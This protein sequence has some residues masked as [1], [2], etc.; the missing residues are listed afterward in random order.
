MLFISIKPHTECSFPNPH[1]ILYTVLYTHLLLSYR[2][3]SQQMLENLYLKEA[4]E[5]LE[6]SQRHRQM[7]LEN[8]VK[9]KLDCT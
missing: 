1:H 4:E 5:D 6:H 3:L 7:K 9:H 2:Q 8:G